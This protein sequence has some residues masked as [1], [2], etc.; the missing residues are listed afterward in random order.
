M[1]KA[2]NIPHV[3]YASNSMSST[4]YASY[5][6]APS[7]VSVVNTATPSSSSHQ[8]ALTSSSNNASSAANTVNRSTNGSSSSNSG[9]SGTSTGTTSHNDTQ[10]LSM[11]KPATGNTGVD[12]KIKFE[13]DDNE[14]FKD[15]SYSDVQINLRVIQDL[16]EGERI[17]IVGGKCVQVDQRYGQSIRRY[18]TSDSRVRALD[19]IEHIIEWSKKYCKEAVAKISVNDDRQG[20]L[21]KLINIQSLLTSSLTGMGRFASTYSDDKLTS[22]RIE[23]FRSTI[24]TFCDEDLKKATMDKSSSRY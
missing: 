8:H 3:S 13:E 22:A 14:D 9:T 7:Q 4:P 17:M 21:N 6:V 1:S 15:L 12:S 5:G 16:K 23:T 18:F 10:L 11:L 2:N 24:Q 19:F 20:N